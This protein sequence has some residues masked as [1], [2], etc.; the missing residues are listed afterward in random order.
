MS[1]QLNQDLLNFLKASP[2]PHH[3]TQNL[4]QKLTSEGFDQ[5]AEEST[6]SIGKGRYFI[7]RGASI[8]AVNLNPDSL[9]DTGLK[10]VGAHTDS[11]C[12]KVKPNPLIE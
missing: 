7:I 8:I 1:S 11:P 2:T 9:T 5:L 12:L 4:A 3:A 6:W 10:M